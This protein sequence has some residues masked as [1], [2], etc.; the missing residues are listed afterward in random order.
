MKMITMM[1]ALF[2]SFSSFAGKD[3]KDE[4]AKGEFLKK[5]LNLSDEQLTKVM[6]LKKNAHNEMKASK[7][8]YQKLRADFKEAMKD[9]KAT[10]L[11]LTTKYEA[12]AKAREDF[13]AKRFQMMLKMREVLTPAQMEKFQDIRKKFKDKFYGKGKKKK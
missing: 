12:V 3:S 2:I 10:N 1:L 8:Q 5:E 4:K 13:Q 11:D 6:E 9:S 7:E